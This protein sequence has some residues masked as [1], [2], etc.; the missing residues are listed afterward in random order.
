MVWKH[1]GKEIKVGYSW[2]DK[3]GFKHPYNWATAWT[4][5]NK[6]DWGITWTDDPDTKFDNRF[7]WSKGIERK[8]A[9]EDATD[10]KGNKLKD[11]DGNQIINEGL[12]TIWVRKT[13]DTANSMLTKTDWYVVRKAEGGSNVPS[14]VTTSRTNIRN[15][16]K[17][18]ED[19]INACSKLSEFMALFDTPVDKDGK[20][21]GNPPIY[22][23]PNE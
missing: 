16:C 9:D 6:K 4:D 23:F 22:D 12:K 3:S 19:K 20:V 18:I 5:K 21:T 11:V 1:D 8:L 13:K 2:V 10:A 7:Y 14:S 15:A 17:T